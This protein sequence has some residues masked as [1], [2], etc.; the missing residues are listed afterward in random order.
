VVVVPQAEGLPSEEVDL[1]LIQSW[2]VEEHC[3]FVAAVM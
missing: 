2:V 1:D 3:L